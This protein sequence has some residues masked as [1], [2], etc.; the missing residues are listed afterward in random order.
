MPER[1]V[2]FGKTFTYQDLMYSGVPNQLAARQARLPLSAKTD[3]NDPVPEF[4][5]LRASQSYE[6][7]SRIGRDKGYSSQGYSREFHISP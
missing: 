1:R 7:E 3:A 5:P 4:E 2:E 6:F